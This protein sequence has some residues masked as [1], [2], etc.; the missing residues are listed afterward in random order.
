MFRP[1]RS[2]R[3]FFACLVLLVV[4]LAGAAIAAA[5]APYDSGQLLAQAD[6]IKTSNHAEFVRLIQLLDRDAT[7]LPSEQQW[8]LRYL[9][10]WQA[11]YIGDYGTATSLINEIL[12]KSA[13]MTLRFRANTSVL[14]V[15][16]VGHHYEEAFEKLRQLLDQMPQIDD[17]TARFQL[18]GEAAQLFT[19]AGQ[20][21]LASG[22][23]DQMLR[24]VPAGESGCK[25]MYLKLD[26]RYKSG[27]L[28]GIDQQFQDGL[29]VCVKAGEI[30]V[31]NA[32]RADI[33]SSNIETG[34]AAAAIS[35][36]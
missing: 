23:A 13:D 33:A 29:D 12:S 32:I 25:S 36:L 6:G 20:Y 15:L 14:D 21:D 28:R 35:L 26:A 11:I 24:E 18:L 19:A 27:L 8:H 22:Y 2:H 30:L 9:N 31:A 17:R 10:A 3:T 34:N 4:F 7:R 5:P 16:R 1:G